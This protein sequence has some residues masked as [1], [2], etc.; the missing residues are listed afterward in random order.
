M[1]PDCGLGNIPVTHPNCAV[2]SRHSRLCLRPVIAAGVAHIKPQHGDAAL[3]PTAVSPT[4]LGNDAEIFIRAGCAEVAAAAPI[5][6][7]LSPLR[8]GAAD[9]TR[10]IGHAEAGGLSIASC[11]DS[12]TCNRCT[13]WCQFEVCGGH[14]NVTNCAFRS[15]YSACLLFRTHVSSSHT[16]P[17]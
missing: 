2:N 17:Q 9:T 13:G 11:E 4:A 14:V 6:A 8:S 16:A 5:A 1:A 7:K 12:C 3:A 10:P 15:Y